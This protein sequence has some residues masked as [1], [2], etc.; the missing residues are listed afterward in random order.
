MVQLSLVKM[1][2]QVPVKSPAGWKLEAGS[3]PAPLEMAF[4]HVEL[5]SIKSSQKKSGVEQDGRVSF[6][7]TAPE[8]KCTQGHT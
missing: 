7:L 8:G 1:C 6:L 5:S 3:T 4:T 2:L